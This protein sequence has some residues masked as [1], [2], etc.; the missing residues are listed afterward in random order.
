[1]D[2]KLTGSVYSTTGLRVMTRPDNTQGLVL[3]VT[4]ITSRGNHSKRRDLITGKEYE[5]D[6]FTC[7]FFDATAQSIASQVIKGQTMT[8]YGELLQTEY[9][10]P[11]KRVVITAKN[12]MYQTLKQFVNAPGC[13]LILAADGSI[14]MEA[15]IAQKGT[16]IRGTQAEFPMMTAQGTQSFMPASNVP[17]ASTSFMPQTAPQYAPAPQAGF[18][19]QTAPQYA[20]APQAGYVAQPTNS[21]VPQTQPQYAPAPAPSF[22]PQGQMAQAPATGF[23]AQNAPEYV[24]QPMANPVA[25]PPFGVGAQVAN[26]AP[27]SNPAPIANPVQEGQVA[28]IQQP[29]AP[30]P[31]TPTFVGAEAPAVDTNIPTATTTTSG[32]QLVATEGF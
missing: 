5:N 9:Q 29:T 27:V 26:T 15:D 23:V 28:V 17:Q 4:I 24:A 31:E 32:M 13:P 30:T 10:S 22:A 19:P 3:S 8:V 6:I 25:E 18:V 2:I 21:F 16:I 14:L 12:P 1:M 20:P 11:L 7:D